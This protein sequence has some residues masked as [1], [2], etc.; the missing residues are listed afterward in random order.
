MIAALL[1]KML[2]TVKIKGGITLSIPNNVG[3]CL[4][5]STIN[6]MLLSNELT[7]DA[8]KSYDESFGRLNM[9]MNRIL[10][11]VNPF[12]RPSILIRLP[13]KI[14]NNKEGFMKLMCRCR[15]ILI[16]N[17]FGIKRAE[18]EHGYFA[19]N[20]TTK[21]IQ[22]I[23]SLYS[24]ML[25]LNVPEQ[26]DNKDLIDFF[27]A[28]G[29]NLRD[30][31]D[32]YVEEHNM[33]IKRFYDTPFSGVNNETF[34]VYISNDNVLEYLSGIVLFTNPHTMLYDVLKQ[35]FV[36]DRSRINKEWK[37][38][39]VHIRDFF[40]KENIIMPEG[41]TPETLFVIYYNDKIKAS[42]RAELLYICNLFHNM[43]FILKMKDS[44][45]QLE[46]YGGI[47]Y[48]DMDATKTNREFFLRMNSSHYRHT[49]ERALTSVPSNAKYL[50]F[51]LGK[52]RKRYQQCN[53]EIYNNAKHDVPLK[54]NQFSW[55]NDEKA[56]DERAMYIIPKDMSPYE[57]E[58]QRKAQRLY[59][60]EEDGSNVSNTFRDMNSVLEFFGEDPNKDIVSEL[61]FK[62][63]NI[64]SIDITTPPVTIPPA[65]AVLL[66][67]R[68]Y[69]IA[70]ASKI[71]AGIQIRTKNKRILPRME[72]VIYPDR[73][74]IEDIEPKLP[75]TLSEEEPI[76]DNDW[77]EHRV[78][79]LMP[80][81]Y[82][83]RPL[84]WN[85][86]MPVWV[87]PKGVDSVVLN[88]TSGYTIEMI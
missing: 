51:L 72:L 67:F 46:P 17:S 27:T 29:G 34:T 53:A 79:I 37:N 75:D 31:I 74:I 3:V 76:D 83:I 77:Q 33:S 55:I 4:G 38:L 68:G 44:G 14:K 58:L 2:H 86:N 22:S 49:F 45:K 56:I 71:N 42:N 9:R 69:N 5:I 8:L 11:E 81:L 73:K 10:E 1:W 60:D 64:D 28:P 43:G 32:E 78:I 80:S 30:N 66:Q 65:H 13:P 36:N 82:V 85:K 21:T 35:N 20:T 84:D 63:I 12:N 26:V 48:K 40:I 50:C 25:Q 61:P 19:S 23:L 15:D 70:Y 6:A 47:Y 24:I 59:V 18:G 41:I 7:F 88:A 16:A 52:I 57:N 87:F 39:F 62:F 54:Y